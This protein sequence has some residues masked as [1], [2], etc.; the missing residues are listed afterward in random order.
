EN[1]GDEPVRML[2]LFRSDH[3]A[4]VSLNQWLGLTPAA[5]VAATLNVSRETVAGMRK[6]KPLIMA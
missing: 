3:F 5:V 4:D 2:E 6:D 1:V